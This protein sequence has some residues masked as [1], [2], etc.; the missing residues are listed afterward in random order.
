MHAYDED[1]AVIPTKGK[2]IIMSQI[3]FNLIAD[4]RLPNPFTIEACIDALLQPSLTP[5]HGLL[6]QVYAN[7]YRTKYVKDNKL[8]AEIEEIVKLFD[9][10]HGEST[11]LVSGGDTL[12]ELF[13]TSVQIQVA[14]DGYEFVFPHGSAGVLRQDEDVLDTWFSS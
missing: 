5:Q 8:I 12:I 14:G 6:Y 1:S 11:S 7:I 2:K 9:A 4:S 3:I 10:V 13:E